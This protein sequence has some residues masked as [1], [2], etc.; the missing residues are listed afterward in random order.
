MS[1]ARKKTIEL[2]ES[3]STDV[4][5]Y[6]YEFYYNYP[7]TK[8]SIKQH[9]KDLKRIKIKVDKLLNKLTTDKTLVEEDIN[10]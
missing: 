1:N 6:A 2:M 7:L 3:L 10:E 8:S 9:I 5:L 4:Q